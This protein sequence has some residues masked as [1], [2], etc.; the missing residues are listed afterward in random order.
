MLFVRKKDR[1]MRLCIDYQHLNKVT[2]K[3]KYPLSRINDL[4][5]QL[6]GTT[7]FFKIGL[8]LGYHQ[9]KV[10]NE[11]IPKTVFQTHY[12]HYEFIVM[13][14]RLTSAPAAFIDL[15]NWV[16]KPFFDHFSIV[17]IDDILI[18]SKN[19]EEHKEHLWIILQTL[20]EN[21]CT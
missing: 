19:D 14:L 8:R 2:I 15:M 9:L 13:S 3:N 4:F 16:F 7:I 5:D 12:R 11:D 6:Q 1:T 21:K 18:Y 20:K 17:F 10:R